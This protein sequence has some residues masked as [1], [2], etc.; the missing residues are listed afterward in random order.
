MGDEPGPRSRIAISRGR[1]QAH[2]TIRAT[3]GATDLER[4][5]ALPGVAR[6]DRRGELAVLSC[7]DSDTAI[8]ALLAA[9]PEARDIEDR[10]RRPGRRIRAAHE[11]W[12]RRRGLRADRGGGM[13]AVAY[14]RFELMRTFRNVR[15]LVF[16]LGFPLIL[17]FAI[18]TPNR[19]E[20]DFADTGIP[21]PLF[22]MVGLVGFGTMTGLIATGARI[23]SE[24]TDG[25]TRQLRITPLTP[26]ACLR[27]KVL[28][29]YAMA[30]L[31]IAVLY[32]SGVVLGVRLPAERWLEMTGLILLGLLP[33]AALGVLVGH[34]LTAD[35]IGPANAG[36]VS[37]LA[38]VSGNWFPVADGVMHDIAQ[39]LPSYWLVQASHVALGGPAWTAT[40]W[41]VIVAWTI[42]LAI[43]ARAA[44]RR[45][46][47]R[48]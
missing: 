25:W 37:L 6:A 2:C 13:T 21:V 14:T 1:K 39:F 47:E 33:F 11:R 43:L 40:G 16:T 45:D 26:R 28:T 17:F 18:A 12:R 35:T 3:L 34:M 23:A 38:L 20:H 10:G 9:H 44:Y 5:A 22:Y 19:N 7:S 30:L 29:G 32:A 46:T 42:A 31:T 27:A 15:L 41:T 4:L 48:V 8:R 36:L 24:R